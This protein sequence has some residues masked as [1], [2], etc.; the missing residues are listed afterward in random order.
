[1][2][3]PAN[4]VVRVPKAKVQGTATT[5]TG[6]AAA[7]RL[8]IGRAAMEGDVVACFVKTE[9]EAWFLGRVVKTAFKANCRF[10]GRRGEL[11]TEDIEHVEVQRLEEVLWKVSRSYEPNT[12]KDGLLYVPACNIVKCKVSLLPPKSTRRSAMNVLGEEWDSMP[13][14]EGSELLASPY[15][16]LPLRERVEIWAVCPQ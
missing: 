12:D 13:R 14:K 9:P 16:H 2:C 11:V 6:T 7:M 4:N 5:R 8:E 1:V 3:G 15:L 10:K